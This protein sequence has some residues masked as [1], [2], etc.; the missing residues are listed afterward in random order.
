MSCSSVITATLACMGIMLSI[1]SLY[2]TSMLNDERFEVPCDMSPTLSCTKFLRLSHATGFGV[3]PTVLGTDHSANMPNSVF[4]MIFYALVL[5][6]SCTNSMLTTTLALVI[7]T[8]L[9][10]ANILITAISLP[11]MCP[12]SLA[13]LG[14]ILFMTLALVC[15]RRSLALE[16]GCPKTINNNKQAFKKFI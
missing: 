12:I 13:S 6:I 8:T 15:R 9:L 16:S 5:I 7:S 11:L 10:L 3:I 1:T 14:T 2:V 4:F